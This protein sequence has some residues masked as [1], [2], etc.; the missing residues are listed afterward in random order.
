MNNENGGD[1][2]SQKAE[3]GTEVVKIFLN[4]YLIN[5]SVEDSLQYL[6]EDARWIGV[7]SYEEVRGKEQIRELI[8][9]EVQSIRTLFQIE[10]LELDEYKMGSHAAQ[11]LCK[12]KIT[13]ATDSGMSMV[14]RGTCGCLDVDGEYK[15]CCVHL[16]T[17]D[18]QNEKEEVFP[19][20]IEEAKIRELKKD[21]FVESIPGGLL[22]INVEENYTIKYANLNLIKLLGYETRSEFYK[23]C[24]FK[25]EE[26]VHPKEWE[27]V[28]RQ[29]EKSIE[30][31]EMYETIYRMRKKDDTYL[32]VLERGK[33]IDDDGQLLIVAMVLDVTMKKESEASLQKQHDFFQELYNSVPCGMAQLTVG[34]NAKFLNANLAVIKMLGYD[35]MEEFKSEERYYNDVVLP[36]YF[37]HMKYELQKLEQLEEG[38]SVVIEYQ[39]QDKNGNKFWMREETQ[40]ITGISGVKIYQCVL[41]DITEQKKNEKALEERYNQ[42]LMYRELS[43]TNMLISYRVNLSKNRVETSCSKV[44]YLDSLETYK[45]YTELYQRILSFIPEEKDKALAD[46]ALNREKLMQGFLEGNS[47]YKVEYKRDPGDGI[48]RWISVTANLMK[49]PDTEDIMAFIYTQDIQSEKMMEN[50]V[51]KVIALDYDYL[52]H[53]DIKSKEYMMFAGKNR[54]NLPMK[55]RGNYDIERK[56]NTNTYVLLECQKRCIKEMELDNVCKELED[57][58]TYNIYISVQEK[59]GRTSKK[60][61]TYSYLDKTYHTLMITRSD[62]TNIYEEEKQKNRMLQYALKSAKK[63]NSAK[64]EF[65][66]RMSHEIRTPMNAIIGM[67]DMATEVPSN[68]RKTKECLM[69][70]DMSSKYLLTLINDILDMSK[71][72]SENFTFNEA[73]FVFRDIL[74][75]VKTIIDSQATNKGVIFQIVEEDDLNCSFIGDEMRLQQVL[76]NLLNNAVKFTPEGGTVTLYIKKKA[77]LSQSVQVEFVVQDTGIGIGQAFLSRLFEPFSQENAGSTTMYDGTGLGL[78]I[79]KNIVALKGGTIDVES[80]KGRGTTFTVLLPLTLSQDSV[81]LLKAKKEESSQ[82]EQT[83]FKRKRILLVEDHP[84]NVEVAKRLLTKKEMIVEVAENG[85]IALEKFSK[86]PIGYYDTILMDIRMPVMDGLAAS[87]NIRLLNRIDSK[88]TPIIAMTAN[89]FEE[90]MEKS[91]AVGMNEHLAKPIDPQKLFATLARYM[92]L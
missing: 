56:R 67:A 49:K 30:Q 36:E 64:S 8:V 77:M 33:C 62:I 57:K 24:D 80:E 38:A 54:T 27:Q 39:A 89:A 85:Q 60:K 18:S 14:V 37:N 3:N 10:Y 65:L 16:S 13:L 91:R 68:P 69:K 86:S 87:M 4:E 23:H 34:D 21:F 92:F 7:S 40:M 50:I 71:I 20:S 53:V 74:S 22:L 52:M 11:V 31:L 32:W 90:D 12:V 44:R 35:S 82:V 59:D 41:T 88:T 84:L 42:E 28:K 15:I 72:E 73:Q 45:V 26:T 47:T 5:R 19:I 51:N 17:S 25:V 78:A 81:Q 1:I 79:C 48:L 58:A 83:Y 76:I 6:T 66:A 9:E 55:V 46:T 29:F 2:V 61:L 43:L 70:I 75:A 63:A